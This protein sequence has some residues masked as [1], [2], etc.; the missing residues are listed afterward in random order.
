MTFRT[1]D[2]PVQWVRSHPEMYFKTG[3]P[4]DFALAQWVWSDAVLSGCRD[5]IVHHESSVWVVGGSANWLV[6]NA[7]AGADLFHRVVPLARGG[8]NSMRSEIL[9]NA[10][11]S[12]VVAVVASTPVFTKGSGSV[13]AIVDDV[14]RQWP[15]LGAAVGFRF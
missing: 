9:L 10:F 15:G 3:K 11:C 14:L 13:N 1:V 12:D 6:E 2:D 5:V 8:P 4:D 7:L